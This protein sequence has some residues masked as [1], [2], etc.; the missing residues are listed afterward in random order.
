MPIKNIFITGLPGVGKTTLVKEILE[1]LK[2]EASGFYTVEIREKGQRKGFK[3]FSLD[4]KEGI[5]A[6][7]EIKSHFRVSKY[8]INLKDLEEIGVKSILDGL[9]EKKLIVI[10]EIGKMELKS[11][12][13]KEAVKLALNSENRI[14]GTIMFKD[15][16]FT[17]RIKRRKDTKIFYL[18]KENREA[19]KKEIISFFPK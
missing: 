19:V 6:H 17:R 12:R 3:I 5:L 13:F 15:N 2:L 7:T 11:G 16:D 14:L 18:T 9:K 4:G 8:K 10:D 1:I